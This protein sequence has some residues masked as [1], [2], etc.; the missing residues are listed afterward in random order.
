MI[1]ARRMK[2]LTG[3]AQAS[4]AAPVD[5]AFALL[6]AVDAYPTW[7][8]EVVKSVDVVERDGAG[9][10]VRVRTHLHLAMGPITHDFHLLMSVSLERP[11]LVRLSR[12]PHEDTDPDRFDVVWRLAA[13]ERTDIR[14]DL[15][16]TLDVPRFLPIGGIGA[17]VARG[18]V[19]AAVKR[20]GG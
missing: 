11:T 15:S 20:L 19:D 12:V 1:D 9:V 10:P 8:P 2:D 13:G 16:A 5:T 6:E 4:T 18:F 7:Y 17:S 14:L 3:T